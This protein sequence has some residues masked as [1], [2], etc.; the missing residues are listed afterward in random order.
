MRMR[1]IDT[2]TWYIIRKVL[3]ST[4]HIKMKLTT[5][6]IIF[7]QIMFIRCLT[8]RYIFHFNEWV[9][10]CIHFNHYSVWFSGCLSVITKTPLIFLY[11]YNS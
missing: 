5:A 2:P 1:A 6:N 7:K 11:K 10:S 8:N 9:I 4:N 3:I